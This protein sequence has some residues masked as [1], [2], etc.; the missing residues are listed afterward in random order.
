MAILLPQT[1]M[2][3]LLLQDMDMAQQTLTETE[4]QQTQQMRMKPKLRLME[5]MMFSSL[6]STLLVP[7]NGQKD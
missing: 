4:T 6:F 2:T 1:Q 3:T 5:A 7:S